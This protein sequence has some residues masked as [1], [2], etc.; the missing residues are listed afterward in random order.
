MSLKF[1][2][3]FVFHKELSLKFR[4]K[5]K[6]NL[7]CKPRSVSRGFSFVLNIL[8]DKGADTLRDSCLNQSASHT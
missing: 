6:K 4:K 2:T 8:A 1:A 5:N 7:L 3:L